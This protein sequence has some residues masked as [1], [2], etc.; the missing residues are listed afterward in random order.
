LAPENFDHLVQ[1]ERRRLEHLREKSKPVQPQVQ[2]S[3]RIEEGA[4]LRFRT[5][6]AVSR[7][8][9][10]E[11]L[12]HLLEC[13]FADRSTGTEQNGEAPAHDQKT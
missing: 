2:M 11:M 3:I 6:C 10:G 5:L 12:L 9:N 7:R 1:L 8:T 13:F 4:Y